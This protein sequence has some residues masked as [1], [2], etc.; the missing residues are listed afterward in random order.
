MEGGGVMFAPDFKS[1]E[2]VDNFL[3]SSGDAWYRPMVEEYMI[4]IHAGGLEYGDELDVE[5]LN[6]WIEHEMETL[7]E[8][9]EEWYTKQENENV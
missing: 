9:Y 1:R 7:T 5:E 3:A 4:L 6:G 8:G 2:D